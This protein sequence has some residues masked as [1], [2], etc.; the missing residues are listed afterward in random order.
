MREVL[1]R[2]TLRLSG[3]K[4][5]TATVR[6][7]RLAFLVDPFDVNLALAAIDACCLLWGGPYHVLIPCLPGGRP[8]D[9]WNVLLEHLD[10]DEVIDLVGAAPDFIEHQKQGLFRQVRRWERPIET[11]LLQGLTVTSVLRRHTD[12]GRRRVLSAVRRFV[13]RGHPLAL[14]LAYRHGHLDRRP[15][16]RDFVM[17]IAYGASRL[18]DFAEVRRIDPNG[19]PSEELIRLVTEYPLAASTPL[20]PSW[21]G[22]PALSVLDVAGDLALAGSA[23]SNASR[24]LPDLVDPEHGDPLEH[25][26]VIVGNPDSV[27]DLCLAW[28]LRARRIP[29]PDPVWVSPEWLG[30]PLVLQRLEAARRANRTLAYGS[31]MP[32]AD[33]LGLTSAS[34]DDEALAALASEVPRSVV[35]PPSRIAAL[36]PDS[37]RIGIVRPSAAVFIDG[38]ADVALPDIEDMADF[39]QFERLGVT[40]DIPNWQLPRMPSPRFGSSNDIVRVAVDG[41]AG[42]LTVDGVHQ[43]R[44]ITVDARDGEEALRA[45]ASAAGYSASIS[46]KGRLAIAVLELFGSERELRLLT[47]SLVY[48]LLTEMAAGIVSRRAVQGILAG[49]PGTSDDSTAEDALLGRL[50]SHLG[51]SQFDRQDLTWDAVF[52][53]LAKAEA[54]RWSLNFLV[55][56]GIAFRG[57]EV[58]CRNCGLRRWLPVDRLAVTHSCD[59][60]RVTL[61]LPLPVDKNLVWRYRL[62]EVVARAVDQG[63]LPHLLVL[64]SLMERYGGRDGELLGAL[65]GVDFRPIDPAGPSQLEAD[66]IAFVAGRVLVAECKATGAS[67]TSKDIEKTLNLARRLGAS[68]A[69]FATTTEFDDKG[70]IAKLFRAPTGLLVEFWERSQLLDPWRYLDRPAPS[71][72]DYLTGVVEP[73]RGRSTN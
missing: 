25:Q 56:R 40:V 23:T 9:L 50:H 24:A 35:C 61:A 51:E 39:A 59:G 60:C 64:C 6:P 48:D 69:V 33:W 20:R 21:V 12:G 46:D 42:S 44:L 14:P 1:L 65:P 16:D 4:Q 28:N 5:V 53:K 32:G 11:M 68:T 55:E 49:L 37:L 22:P 10:P 66:V 19:L 57:Y 13:L 63:A 58:V 7:L 45:V 41:L 18:E 70:E 3:P 2:S 38:R 72:S 43:Y 62:N 34:L 47:S 26:I 31:R 27:P 54:A 30:D 73:L 71:P 8:D 29:H 17:S 15:M 36:L 52:V 67:L